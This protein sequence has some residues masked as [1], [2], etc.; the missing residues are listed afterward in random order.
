MYIN[1]EELVSLMLN[2]NCQDRMAFGFGGED[3]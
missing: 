3:L 2:A 1:F